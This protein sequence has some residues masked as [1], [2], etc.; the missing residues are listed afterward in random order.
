MVDLPKEHLVNQRHGSWPRLT[1]AP[2]A[3]AFI[4]MT[5]QQ[6]NIAELTACRPNAHKVF[7]NIHL[8]PKFD[9][10]RH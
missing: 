1:V 6:N 8:S 4:R 9:M 10:A 5:K 7:T 3:D 2:A